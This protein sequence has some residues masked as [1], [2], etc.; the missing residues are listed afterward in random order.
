MQ[1]DA[2]AG[3]APLNVQRV[4]VVDGQ[5]AHAVQ[6]GQVVGVQVAGDVVDPQRGAL[7]ALDR[8]FDAL[9]AHRDV[10]V[11]QQAQARRGKTVGPG[12]GWRKVFKQVQARA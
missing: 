4:G 7:V 6:I 10:E 12:S 2:A 8:L 3:L 1:P 9:Q 5:G 11:A